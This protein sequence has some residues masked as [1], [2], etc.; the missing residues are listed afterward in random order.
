MFSTVAEF[1]G[2][3]GLDVIPPTTFGELVPYLLQV[4]VGLILA[5]MT[6]RLV[7]GVSRVFSAR[8]WKV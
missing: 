3:I 7:L 1:F 8:W 6:F 2:I 5:G 4:G